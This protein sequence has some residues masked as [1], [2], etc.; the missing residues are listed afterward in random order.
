MSKYDDKMNVDH[1]GYIGI[2]LLYLAWGLHKVAGKFR[3]GHFTRK[4]SFRGWTWIATNEDYE[5]A[6]RALLIVACL[7]VMVALLYYKAGLP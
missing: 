1:W 7:G 3:R 6:M 2:A 5:L 4:M